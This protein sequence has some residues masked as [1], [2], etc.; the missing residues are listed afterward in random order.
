MENIF[1]I[2]VNLLIMI[3]ENIDN[4]MSPL[5]NFISSFG[6]TVIS[7]ITNA[8]EWLITALN[9]I[10]ELFEKFFENFGVWHGSPGGG[11]GGGGSRPAL[12]D[13]ISIIQLY[14]R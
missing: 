4:I 13:L 1:E 6:G 10:I 8:F 2:F 12:A 9:S 7:L 11:G 14:T 3:W 5:I